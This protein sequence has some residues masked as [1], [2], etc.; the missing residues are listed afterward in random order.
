VGPELIASFGTKALALKYE[1]N[2]AQQR[3][4][5]E[6]QVKCYGKGGA[7]EIVEGLSPIPGVRRVRVE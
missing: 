2:V 3:L 4:R 5:I 6:F 7:A 1:K